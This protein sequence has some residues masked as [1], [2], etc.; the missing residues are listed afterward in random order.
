[1]TKQLQ[2]DSSFGVSVLYWLCGLTADE[3]GPTRRMVEDLQGFGRLP[4]PVKRLDLC[5]PAELIEALSELCVKARSEVLLPI[6]HLDMH[7][8]LA[9]GR[10]CILDRRAR[11]SAQAM[12]V[13]ALF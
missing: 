13:S 12:D 10:G 4:I 6:V 3:Q 9:Q 8:S 1:M 11:F 2:L 7:G 5:E